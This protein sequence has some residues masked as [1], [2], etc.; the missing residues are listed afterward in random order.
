MRTLENLANIPHLFDADLNMKVSQHM[1]NLQFA[2]YTQDS[3]E[4]HFVPKTEREEPC[5]VVPQ[6]T[7]KL[8]EDLV[9]RQEISDSGN[10]SQNPPLSPRTEQAPRAPPEL[11]QLEKILKLIQGEA[12]ESK[13]ILKSMNRLL[14]LI[15]SGQLAIGGM[16]KYYHV[17]KNPVNRQGIAATEYGLE[18]LRFGYYQDGFRFRIAAKQDDLVADYLKFF[19]VG[20]HLIKGDDKPRLIDGKRDE[21]ER[22]LLKE[23][24]VSRL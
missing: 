12:S 3:S 5:L 19:G 17:F 4:G 8:H 1:F 23:L 22:L 24:G 18:P 7:Q 14:T 2:R 21:A 10:K 15:Q 6:P 20:N 11:S 13:D 9:P 16:D